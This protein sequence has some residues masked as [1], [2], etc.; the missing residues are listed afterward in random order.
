[1]LI[2]SKRVYDYKIIYFII[3]GGCKLALVE[4][5]NP[6]VMQLVIIPII[7]IGSGV[8]VSIIK[9]KFYIGPIITLIFNLLVEI[10]FFNKLSS[11][12][13]VFLILSLVFSFIFVRN[14]KYDSV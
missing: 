2:L 7:S 13:F 3:R 1:M 4:N 14:D 6:L 5:V 8:L 10:L 12:I 9:K 11:W